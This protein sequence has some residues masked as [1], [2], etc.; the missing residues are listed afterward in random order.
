MTGALDG[1][2]TPGDPGF[3]AKSF[4]MRMNENTSDAFCANVKKESLP[5]CDT[6]AMYRMGLKSLDE[7]GLNALTAKMPESFSYDARFHKSEVRFTDRIGSFHDKWFKKL[8]SRSGLV[9]G[10][11]IGRLMIARL[12]NASSTSDPSDFLYELLSGDVGGFDVLPAAPVTWRTHAVDFAAIVGPAA[13]AVAFSA[14][15]FHF[16]LAPRPM[17]AKF[18]TLPS[19]AH[20][21]ALYDAPSNS[22]TRARVEGGN[23][24]IAVLGEPASISFTLPSQ[25]LCELEIVVG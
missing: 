25:L 4:L 22:T 14:K 19:G 5:G 13:G 7:A 12:E 2:N 23:I 3:M 21:W 11:A 24:T 16:G 1:G 10:P 17:G 18:L 6:H 8:K 15:L 20:E 9:L